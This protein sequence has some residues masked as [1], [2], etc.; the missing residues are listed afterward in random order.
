MHCFRSTLI[1]FFL[2]GVIWPHPGPF[3]HHIAATFQLNSYLITMATEVSITALITFSP[4]ETSFHLT[5]MAKRDILAPFL[6]E[7]ADYW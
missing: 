7:G 4:G 5:E 1:V 3:I 6:V 2:L